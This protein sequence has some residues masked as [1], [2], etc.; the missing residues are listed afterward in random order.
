M[1]AAMASIFPDPNATPEVQRNFICARKI[2]ISEKVKRV[3]FVTIVV[4]GIISLLS[5]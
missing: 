2:Q 1:K 3:G 4:V 5:V